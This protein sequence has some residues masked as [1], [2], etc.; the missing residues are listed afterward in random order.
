MWQ[1]QYSSVMFTTACTIGSNCRSE[2]ARPEVQNLKYWYPNQV[3][4]QLARRPQHH[5]IEWRRRMSWNRIALTR[6]ETLPPPPFTG[7]AVRGRIGRH[8]RRPRI[9]ASARAWASCS[10][11]IHSSSASRRTCSR[12]PAITLAIQ[13]A[14]HN[15]R[16]TMPAILEQEHKYAVQHC[17]SCHA[18]RVPMLQ[19]RAWV[20]RKTRHHA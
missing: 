18:C 1:A 19:G 2:W 11:W 13:R 3:Q 17:V 14:K 15:A 5:A 8:S 12:P 4:T 16:K 9:A 7:W 6:Q 20:L 10:D